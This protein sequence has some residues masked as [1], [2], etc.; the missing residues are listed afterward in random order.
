VLLDLQLAATKHYFTID[1]I[2][3]LLE[4]FEY[5]RQV[6]SHVVICMFSRIM[7]PYR[8][9]VFLRSLER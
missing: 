9:D 6:Q 7:D 4:T 1:H 3:L 2:N 5:E 8:I